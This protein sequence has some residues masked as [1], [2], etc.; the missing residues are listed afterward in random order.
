[1]M[2]TLLFVLVSRHYKLEDLESSANANARVLVGVRN[3]GEDTLRRVKAEKVCM[4]SP[5]IACMSPT[6]L[7]SGDTTAQA[8]HRITHIHV[9]GNKAGLTN[10]VTRQLYWLRFWFGS[11]FFTCHR[12]LFVC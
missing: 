7:I 2:A 8:G 11:F 9:D 1:M 4:T 6:N 12:C 5:Q 10:V 3:K